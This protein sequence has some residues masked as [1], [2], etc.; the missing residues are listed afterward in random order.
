VANGRVAA[1][2]SKPRSWASTIY[3]LICG[4]S[5][6][7]FVFQAVFFYSAFVSKEVQL[8]SA[9]LAAALCMPFAWVMGAI[10]NRVRRSNSLQAID[11]SGLLFPG[12]PSPPWRAP[13]PD[14][15]RPSTILVLLVASWLVLFFWFLTAWSLGGMVNSIMQGDRGRSAVLSVIAK[16]ACTSTRCTCMRSLT[17]EG[18]LPHQSVEVCVDGSFWAGVQVGESVQAS[19]FFAQRSVFLLRFRKLPL[20]TSAAQ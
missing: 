9:L 19:G 15:Y 16:E 20:A 13:P 3:W 6:S 14:R 11:R 8:W 5:L 4:F 2:S 7:A 1:M 10:R 12:V 17:L 18:A